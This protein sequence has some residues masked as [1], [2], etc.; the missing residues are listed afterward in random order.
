[1]ADGAFLRAM[2][3][4]F[5]PCMSNTESLSPIVKNVAYVALSCSGL[6]RK[7]PLMV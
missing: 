1:M 2:M 7:R 6:T 4:E 5:A 3:F